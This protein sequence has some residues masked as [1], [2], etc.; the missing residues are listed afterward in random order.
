MPVTPFTKK[1]DK[2]LNGTLAEFEAEEAKNF[3]EWVDRYKE[4][5]LQENDDN[6]VQFPD[7]E[8]FEMELS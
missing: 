1:F 6:P 7:N 8:H 3:E 2:F 5:N 4:E